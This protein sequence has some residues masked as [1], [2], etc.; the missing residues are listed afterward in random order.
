M[1]GNT[2]MRDGIGD[3]KGIGNGKEIGNEK[4]NSA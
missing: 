1:V 4:R 3:E 2:M